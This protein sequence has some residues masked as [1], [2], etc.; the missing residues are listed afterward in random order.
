[1]YSN[2][3]SRIEC[4]CEEGEVRRSN[5]AP[6]IRMRFVEQDCFAEF[7]LGVADGETRGLA[8]RLEGSAMPPNTPPMPA[9]T[10]TYIPVRQDWLDRRREPIL[11]P[12]L[13]IINPH[14]HLWDRAGWRYLLD[15]LL[16]DTDTGHNILATVYVQARS[17][18]RVA[19]PEEMKPV[20]ETEFVNGVAA[21]CAS[22]IYGKI[23][24]AAGIVA[25]ADL[26]LGD[27]VDPVLA[28]HERAGGGRFRGIR[29]ITAWDAD[30]SIRNPA[31]NP[32]PGLMADAKFRDGF[33]T[34]GRMGFSF[35][36][37]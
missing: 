21:M 36:A 31:Y 20:G 19:G 10:P 37:W 8:M 32:P 30:A 18:H 7:I 17:M 4:H 22:G 26:T 11:K 2:F 28:A 5:L 14:H 34:L 33:R 27:R 24:V 1:M 35:D 16:A 25:H 13:A 12:E 15:E 9:A 23:R 6:Q 3:A 29:H